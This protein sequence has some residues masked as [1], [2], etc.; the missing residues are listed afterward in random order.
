MIDGV[1][2]DKLLDDYFTKLLAGGA[3]YDLV[4]TEE[5][6]ALRRYLSFEFW[7][8]R[9]PNQ[10]IPSHTQTT[11]SDYTVLVD[12]AHNVAACFYGKTAVSPTKEAESC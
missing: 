6:E 9:V 7:Y 2:L 12:E 11:H 4:K 8:D 3:L 5:N 10:R 1:P